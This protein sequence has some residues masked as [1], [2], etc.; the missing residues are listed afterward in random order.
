MPYPAVCNW[1]IGFPLGNFSWLIGLLSNSCT[2]SDK[3][4]R[5][6]RRGKLCTEPEVLADLL[7]G[8]MKGFQAHRAT[9]VWGKWPWRLQ[10]DTL[11]YVFHGKQCF[12]VKKYWS[13][14]FAAT[15]NQSYLGCSAVARA[16]LFSLSACARNFITLK[17]H[18]KTTFY[19]L[20][21]NISTPYG[22]M[23]YQIN[24][25]YLHDYGIYYIFWLMNA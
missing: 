17:Y 4:E 16:S 6:R 5:R 8:K 10:K 19:R 2:Q 18:E 7:C 21:F 14:S 1:S 24:Q 15:A 12:C 22:G 13:R 9:F 20:C 23:V 25:A 11:C 3:H